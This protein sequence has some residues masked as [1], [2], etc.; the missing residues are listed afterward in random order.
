[1]KFNFISEC[2]KFYGLKVIVSGKIMPYFTFY[3]ITKRNN[4]EITRDIVYH[5]E[6]I[7]HNGKGSVISCKKTFF[8]NK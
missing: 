2:H 6:N 4:R 3:K 8:L 1:M 7:V 5:W